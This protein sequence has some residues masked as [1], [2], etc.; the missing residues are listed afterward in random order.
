MLNVLLTGVG[1]QGTVLAAKVLAQAALTKGWQVRTAETIGM[2]QRGGSVT[3]HVRMGSGGEEVHS[4]LL[5]KGSADL[6][7]A[8][9]PGEAARVLPYLAPHGVLVTAQTPIQ[10]ITAAAAK[11]PYRS[12]TVIAGIK[13]ALAADFAP[14]QRLIVVD[15]ESLT[16]QVG[17]RKAL[18]TVLLASAL[19]TGCIPISIDDLKSAITACVKPRFIDMNL[20]AV[21]IATA[22]LAGK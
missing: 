7:I 14:A 19:A 13:Q 11:E 6:I 3:S 9:E 1:G 16:Q 4:P 5:T 15:D 2:A 21:D 17:S 18:N 22:A 8:F 20:A 12:E 10:P